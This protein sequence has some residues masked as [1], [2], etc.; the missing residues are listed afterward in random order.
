MS[1]NQIFRLWVIFLFAI[2][3]LGGSTM[4]PGDEI[5]RVR[6]FTRVIE[7]DYVGWTINAIGTK[8]GQAVLG[9]E[10]YLQLK[11]QRMVISEYLDLIRRIQEIE[12]Q[13][14]DIHADPSTLDPIE[15]SQALRLE[16][17]NN[18]FSR[19]QM[20]PLAES[21]LQSQIGSVIVNL[22]LDLGGQP[23][24][25]LLY[26]TTPPPAALIVSPK[27]EIRQIANISIDPGLPV[28]EQEMLEDKVDNALTVSTLVVPI[29]GVGIYP[30]MV[31]QTTDLNWLTEVVAHEWVHNFLTLRP[32]GINFM[33]S[34]DLRT[35]NET[36][37]AI[38]GKE[39]GRAVMERY[40]PEL[41]PPEPTPEPETVPQESEPDSPKA[42]DFRAEMRQ[43]REV[44]D[45]LLAEGKIEQ[46]E[47]YM[48]LRR[49]YFWDFGYHIRKLNQAY[50]AFHGAYADQPGGAAG[51]DPVGTAVRTLREQSTS[52]A[53]FLNQISWMWSVEQL[54]EAVSNGG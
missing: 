25:P 11:D 38:A 12:A 2:L 5:E 8:L 29:G 41:V 36:T 39:I 46:A 37:A 10:R 48:E 26:H 32:L 21:I 7:F 42:F 19:K 1:I 17:E 52:L 44:T 13:L 6:A 24:P 45:R 33:T 3:L 47:I 23:I 16:Q 31:M 51:E 54:N 53:D 20:E 22:N 9:T 14:Y 27:D 50:F 35:M 40:Y 34:P 15:V 49:R 4:P 28:D 18:H 43:T 30:T